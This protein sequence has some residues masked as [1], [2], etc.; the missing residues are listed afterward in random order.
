[1]IEL[2]ISW[3]S[4]YKISHSYVDVLIFK[5]FFWSSVSGDY[6]TISL[7]IQHRVYIKF[8]TNVG[9]NAK[10]TVT[11]I[12]QAFREESMSSTRVFEWHARFRVDRKG[13][14]M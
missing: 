9:K 11:V 12:Q 6:D 1:M 13:R 8:R 10:E 2:S 3:K 7:W 4:V 5:S 14:E